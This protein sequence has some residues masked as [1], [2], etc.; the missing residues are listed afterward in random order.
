[1]KL[2]QIVVGGLGAM[3]FFEATYAYPGMGSTVREIE[4]RVQDRQRRPG[5]RRVPSHSRRQAT[6]VADP[7]EVE[8]P[9]EV[10]EPEDENEVE[11]PEDEAEDVPVL[12]G[13]IKDGGSTPV[14]QAIARIIQEQ[15]T[16]QSNEGYVIP[17]GI[18]TK[19]CKA[20][21]CC[22]WAHVSAQLTKL[23]RG[24]S[25]RCNKNARAA[26]RLGFHDAGTWQEGLD[27]GGADGSIILSKDEISR[28]DNKGLQDIYVSP[29]P[30]STIPH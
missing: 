23:F 10:E 11:D 18:N 5:F 27:F 28:P 1:M 22:V 19:L 2:S 25:G 8:D 20:D 7:A 9:N 13:D 29:P 24:S 21:T 6:E 15:E 17:G 30:H 26:I 4:Q 3:T 14:G 16:G 12:I